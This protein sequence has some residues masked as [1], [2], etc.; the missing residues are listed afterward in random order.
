MKSPLI[1]PFAIVSLLF[2]A[3]EQKSAQITSSSP[4]SSPAPTVA[5]DT[6]DNFAVSPSS[7]AEA[8]A[9][10]EAAISPPT[11]GTSNPRP[12]FRNEAA[13]EAANRYLNSYNTVLNDV[14]AAPG[15]R[16]A[17]PTDPRAAL[18]A[19]MTQARKIGQDTRDVANQ[20]KQ[21]DRL[22]APDEKKRLR[23][24]Q[25]SLEQGSQDTNENQ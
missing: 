10:A 24:Y 6:P 5:A 14:T 13:T 25:R 8:S 20:Q 17:I 19:V 4:P 3:C 12:V 1:A 9:T 22:L 7:S 21:V 18:E 23:E 15:T 16:P 2:A 11:S